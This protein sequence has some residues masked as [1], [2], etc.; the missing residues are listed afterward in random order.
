VVLNEGSRESGDRN[1][2][3]SGPNLVKAAEQICQELLNQ[4]EL[5][6][7]TE[8]LKPGDKLELSSKRKGVKV[9]APTR[10]PD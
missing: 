3:V 9:N 6:F 4:Y 1:E 10:L 7:S 2:Q 8:G 5:S